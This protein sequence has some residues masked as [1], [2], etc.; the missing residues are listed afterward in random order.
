MRGLLNL[1]IGP[2]EFFAVLFEHLQFGG[3]GVLAH[4]PEKV[5][6]IGIFGDESKCFL[7]AHAANQNRWMRFAEY[8]WAINRPRK[9]MIFTI[10]RLRIALPH[11]QCDLQGFFKPLKTLLDGREWDA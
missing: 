9:L 5:A 3:Y 1:I 2:S 8:L 4:P 6:G 10:D 11:L 7:F